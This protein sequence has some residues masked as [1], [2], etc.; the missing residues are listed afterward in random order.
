[1]DTNASLNREPNPFLKAPREFQFA[2]YFVDFDHWGRRVAV[3]LF[4]LDSRKMIAPVRG[5]PDLG[6]G[7]YAVYACR[8]PVRIRANHLRGDNAVLSGLFFDP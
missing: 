6:G 2:L 3:E 8:Q 4:D 1:M 5:F 7:A